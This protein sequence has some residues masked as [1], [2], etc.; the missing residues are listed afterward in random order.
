MR[1]NLY[2]P[3]ASTIACVLAGAALAVSLTHAGPRGL[4]GPHG[5]AGPA[6]K[7]GSTAQSAVT[8]R[9]GTCWKAPATSNGAGAV[10]VTWV[11]ISQPVLADGVCTCPDGS[12]FTSIVPAPS[13]SANG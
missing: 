4:A 11:S 8:A 1:N 7:N 13:A 10:R 6:G 3:I 9:L 5:Q 2:A 12:T